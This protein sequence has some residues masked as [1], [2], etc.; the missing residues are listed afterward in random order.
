MNNYFVKFDDIFSN[1]N[2]QNFYN[3]MSWQIIIRIH[4]KVTHN[5]PRLLL[6]ESLLQINININIGHKHNLQ[7]MIYEIKNTSWGKYHILIIYHLPKYV[8]MVILSYN[9][10][11]FQTLNE[12]VLFHWQYLDIYLTTNF[13]KQLYLKKN[14]LYDS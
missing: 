7:D 3:Y 1:T 12:I 14:Y 4:I 13:F 9:S 2:L 5:C 8:K 6:S 10:F 11:I